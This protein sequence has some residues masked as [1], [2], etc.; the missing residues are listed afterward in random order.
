MYKLILDI[1][2]KKSDRLSYSTYV[3]DADDECRFQERIQP[4][5]NFVL[6]LSI[7]LIR[8]TT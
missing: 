5:R 2:K 3:R 8:F 1:I 7:A 6:L 4:K